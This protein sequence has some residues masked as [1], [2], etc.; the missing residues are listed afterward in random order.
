[1]PIVVAKAGTVVNSEANDATRAVEGAAM[2]IIDPNPEAQGQLLAPLCLPCSPAGQ[3]S[4]PAA[5]PAGKKPKNK[6]LPNVVTCS[7][8]HNHYHLDCHLY[9]GGS[10]AEEGN[11]DYKCYTCSEYKETPRCCFCPRMG[12]AFRPTSDYR[13]SHVFCARNCP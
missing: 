3:E 12:G 10:V 8:C 5:A 7:K 6:D 4:G 11:K 1:M 13:V 9:A 2:A